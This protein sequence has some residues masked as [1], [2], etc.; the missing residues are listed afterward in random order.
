MQMNYQA[1]WISRQRADAMRR[2]GRLDRSILLDT[3]NGY[4]I[5]EPA[6]SNVGDG[7]VLSLEEAD[8]ELQPAWYTGPIPRLREAR[9]R[10]GLEADVL[11][12]AG[13]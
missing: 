2:A 12:S 7:A 8:Y 9:L 5:V 11:V 10:L 13:V 1:R 6:G 4:V 3:F